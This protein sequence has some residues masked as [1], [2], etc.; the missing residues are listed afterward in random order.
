MMKRKLV[1]VLVTMLLIIALCKTTVLA[2]DGEFTIKAG[3][4]QELS[5]SLN[6][7]QGI[8]YNCVWSSSSTCVQIVTSSSGATS[9][10]S[11]AGRST[12]TYKCTVKGLSAGT[13]VI[14][15]SGTAQVMVQNSVY[16]PSNPFSPII[17]YSY[18][19]V[20]HTRTFTIN[21]TAAST[22]TTSND[23]TNFAS[24]N[25]STKEIAKGKTLKLSI[26]GSQIKSV[27]WTTS[28]KN[29]VKIIKGT[30]GKTVTL[31]GM[32]KGKIAKIKAIVTFKDK[33]NK[34]L[35]RKITVK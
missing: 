26:V 4:T 12:N 8:M 7:L 18:K 14:T 25:Q 1:S 19:T 24:F 5:F 3:E 32:K 30:N 21:V 10:D 28:N 22:T 33:T 2:S 9:T 29:N 20:T 11:L 34:T 16:N 27:K 31:K 17:T 35:T 23:T 13:A 15:A 6:N